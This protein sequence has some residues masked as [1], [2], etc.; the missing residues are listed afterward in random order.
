M[1]LPTTTH[2]LRQYGG[3][4]SA[5]GRMVHTGRITK[6]IAGLREDSALCSVEVPDPATTFRFAEPLRTAVA[7]WWRR[8]DVA[9]E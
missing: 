1:C 5:T 4:G 8:L 2:W 6:A 7:G 3:A 9:G